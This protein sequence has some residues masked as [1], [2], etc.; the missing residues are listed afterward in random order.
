MCALSGLK[1]AFGELKHSYGL[2]R[3]LLCPSESKM[4]TKHLFQYCP[5]IPC[6]TAHFYLLRETET[7][8]KYHPWGKRVSDSSEGAV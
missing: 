1:A 3:G 8:R 5:F 6:C 2:K 7:E 4:C